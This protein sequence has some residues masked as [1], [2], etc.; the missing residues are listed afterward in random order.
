MANEEKGYWFS[1]ENG[2]HIHAEEGE[3][4]ES[5]M[6]KKFSNFGK[7]EESWKDDEDAIWKKFNKGEITEEER[8]KYLSERSGK[9]AKKDT[10]FEEINAKRMGTDR[11]EF[12]K[13]IDE[14]S[15]PAFDSAKKLDSLYKNAKEKNLDFE[16]SLLNDIKSNPDK[17]NKIVLGDKEYIRKG[18]G[19]DFYENGKHIS[20]GTANSVAKDISDYYEDTETKLNDSKKISYDEFFESPSNKQ[21]VDDYV[22]DFMFRARR[23]NEQDNVSVDKVLEEFKKDWVGFYSE[24]TLPHIEKRIQEKLGK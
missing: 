9:V 6:K 23:N 22:E 11:P 5:A 15:K 17:Y 4:K 3:S 21:I 2:T 24:E 16:R 10:T 14:E 18:N 13:K 8:N 1:T 20:F 12:A 7:K 19:F